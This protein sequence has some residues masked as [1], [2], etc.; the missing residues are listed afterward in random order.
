MF[1]LRKYARTGLWN[2][3]RQLD[4]LFSCSLNDVKSILQHFHKTGAPAGTYCEA[5]GIDSDVGV[6]ITKF[7]CDLIQ[8]NNPELWTLENAK[9]MACTVELDEIAEPGPSLAQER[10]WG[11]CIR[12]SVREEPGDEPEDPAPAIKSENQ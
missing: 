7:H 1:H 9:D 10:T 11:C 6:C 4:W 8:D 2:L 12:H 5:N 3:S